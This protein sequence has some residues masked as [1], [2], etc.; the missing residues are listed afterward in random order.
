[1]SDNVHITIGATENASG[2][3]MEVGEAA[4]RT[5]RVI[6]QSMGDTEDA[7][8]S[9]ARGASDFGSKLDMAAGFTGAMA[10][11]L[12]GVGAAAS[13]VSDLMSYSAR[14]AE[15]LAR[16]KIDVEQAAQDASQAIEDMAQAN[17][18]AAQAGI[19]AEQADQDAEQAILDKAVAQKAYNE[20]V[21]EFGSKSPEARQAALDL[22]QADIDH[23]QALE[24]SAQAQRD[25]S[26]A[27]LD[28]K[29]ALIDQKSATNDLTASQRELENQSSILTKIADWTGMLGGVLSGL[30]GIIG[31]V[32]AAQWLWNIAMTANPIGLV[33]TAIGI[34]IG[35]IVLIATKTDWFQK[36]WR[37]IW[38]KIGGPVTSAWNTV[39]NTVIKTIAIVITAIQR[40]PKAI[41][42][43]FSSLSRILTA[44]FRSAFG[45]IKALWN[46]T[47]GGF[48]FSIP[49]WV[50]GIGGASFQFPSMAVGGDVLRSGL[51]FIHAGERIVPRAQAQRIPSGR[52]ADLAD[53]LRGMQEQ[54]VDLTISFESAFSD[55]KIM[56]LIIEGIRAHVKSAGGGNV[57]VALGR[58]NQR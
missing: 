21:A 50:P 41:S 9:A 7:F 2:I 28:G 20:A 30:V 12:D 57:Q 53:R 16:A 25:A 48:G 3:I 37:S 55:S 29:Q 33:V 51:A 44:P 34:L 49:S 40:L 56:K 36:L 27:L 54:K 1:M 32:T 8:D 11:G 24:D 4:Q 22:S 31:A 45:A 18:D 42:K 39:K 23:K 19:D 58:G 52:H 43:A 15:D 35:V 47:V 6:T 13:S 14:K 46:S 38:G 17:R 10:E 5:E 26:Q